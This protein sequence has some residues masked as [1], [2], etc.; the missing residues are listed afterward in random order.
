MERKYVSKNGVVERTRYVVGDRATPRNRKRNKSTLRKEEQNFN[1]A[2][3]RVAR[4]LNCNFDSSALLLTLDYSTD[5]MGKLCT[6]LPECERKILENLSRRIGAIGGWTSKENGK[7][8]KE[9]QEEDEAE[10][11]GAAFASLREAAEH[12]FLLWF[13][14]IKRKLGAKIKILA[15][16][17]D[18]DHETGEVVRL[19][20]HVVLQGEGLSWDLIREEWKLGSVDIR[21]LRNQPDYTP[22]AVY[23]M[24]QVRRQPDKKKYRVSRGMEMPEMTER[25]VLGRAEMKAPAGAT[26]FERGAFS[27]DNVS[28]YIRYLPK[29]KKRRKS[30]EFSE[31]QGDPP[32]L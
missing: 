27:T 28:Q 30:D 11:I 32:D 4:I 6:S 3:R 10:E 25:E 5:G 15:V 2:I 22:I 26:V 13:R 9:R 8:K 29:P 7:R 16:T 12:Q 23:L 17:S 20:H 18:I 21:Q 19:H 31:I 24:R 1:S 14:R